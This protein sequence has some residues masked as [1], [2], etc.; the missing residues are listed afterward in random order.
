LAAV[1]VPPRTVIIERLPALPPKP[2]KTKKKLFL[3]S[4]ISFFF[5]G[6]IIIERWVPYGAQAKRQT[7][8]QRAAAAK[9]YPKPRN[10]IIVYDAVQARVIRQF[11][12]LG[13]TQENP[14]AYLARYGVSLL[15]SSTLVQQARAAGVVEDIVSHRSILH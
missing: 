4:K 12:R 6:D 11:Q 14:Q 13:V 7:I 15:E 2:R 1:P 10:L 5:P 9:E 8:V 3:F